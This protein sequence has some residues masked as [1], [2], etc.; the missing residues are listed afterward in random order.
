MADKVDDLYEELM[1]LS[2]QERG[3]LRELLE[4]TSAGDFAS[5]EIRQA[6]ID[7]A[8]RVSRAVHEGR[9]RTYPADEVMRELRDVVAE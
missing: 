7:L 6:W 8:D 9:E 3:R 5:L 2:E 4:Q 1:M